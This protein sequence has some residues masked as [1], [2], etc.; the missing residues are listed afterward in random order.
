QLADEDGETDSDAA[1]LFLDH[2]RAVLD[3]H[4]ATTIRVDEVPRVYRASRFRLEASYADPA[5]EIHTLSRTVDVWPSSVQAG[6]RAE[7]WDKTDRDIPVTLK[8]LG[9]G[10]E[11]R[12]DVPMVLHVIERK[13]HTV[14]KRMVGGFYRYE[15][16]TSRTDMGRAC[17]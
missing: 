13:L 7:G 1:A 11:P 16:H 6:L 9:P 4:G 5:G 8:A 14:R 3:E 15:S 2:R 17:E 10:L 12:Q